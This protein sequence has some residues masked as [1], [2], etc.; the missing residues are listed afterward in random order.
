MTG[1][2]RWQAL[3]ALGVLS[4][5]TA[6][7]RQTG[8]TQPPP[9]PVEAFTVGDAAPA[10]AAGT[11]YP[12]TIAR[13]REAHLSLRVVGV[14]TALPVRIGDRLARGALIGRVEAI[15]YA[16]NAARA[17]AEVTRLERDASRNEVLLAAGAI[18]REQRDD[19]LTALAAARATAKN[20]AYDQA[21]TMLRMPFVGTILSREA[22]VGE[23]M[24]AGQPWVSVA[25]TAS[26]LVAKAQVAAID[27]GGLHPGMSAE[28]MLPGG[29][30]PVSG[31][32][33]RQGAA[34]D[35][36]TAT[37]EVDVAL[38]GDLRLA[39]G[40]LAAVRFADRAAMPSGGE[41]RVPDEALVDV[42]HGL[43]HVFIIDRQQTARKLAVHVLGIDGDWI[44]LT[45]LPADARVITAGAGFV[46][47]GQRVTVANK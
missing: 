35:A 27:A 2:F 30:P 11:S 5:L 32:I 13:D 21:S 42:S 3:T 7:Q 38:P 45:G 1:A 23:I 40:T 31:R 47:A 25:D 19:A 17:A 22:E 24:A 43:G 12:A 28:V 14:V 26:P 39:S 8:P 33:M 37:V 4:C 44:R 41:Q 10:A 6:C 34:G 9:L 20:A 15:P 16:A 36:N 18:S 29:G 46:A